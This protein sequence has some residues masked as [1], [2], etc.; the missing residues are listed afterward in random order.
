M[1]FFRA[2][3]IL[4]LSCSAANAGDYLFKVSENAEDVTVSGTIKA[5]EGIKDPLVEELLA[6][7]KELYAS[8]SGYDGIYF[9]A[10]G[11]A[12]YMGN[13]N[14]GTRD[15]GFPSPNQWYNNEDEYKRSFGHIVPSM[16]QQFN[17]NKKV[18]KRGD[19]GFGTTMAVGKKFWKGL[20]GEIELGYR[21]GGFDDVEI[22]ATKDMLKYETT[23]GRPVNWGEDD[24]GIDVVDGGYRTRSLLA[25]L[26]FDIPLTERF[27]PYV[28]AGVGLHWT[29]VNDGMSDTGGSG[30]AYQAM[31]GLNFKATDQ[32]ELFAGYRYFSADAVPM[33]DQLMIEVDTHN[34]EA[35]L[36]FYLDSPKKKVKDTKPPKPLDN[37]F[38][39]G[40]SGGLVQQQNMGN[41]LNEADYGSGIVVSN[42]EWK[43]GYGLEV[44]V[45]YRVCSWCRVEL[46][47]SYK[48]S[49]LASQSYAS[50]PWEDSELLTIE[51]GKNPDDV[52]NFAIFHALL[53]NFYADLNIANIKE[54]YGILPFLGVGLGGMYIDIQSPRHDEGGWNSFSMQKGSFAAQMS[55]GFGYSLTDQITV[56]TQYKYLTTLGN[57]ELF[58]EQNR[59]VLTDIEKSNKSY[60]VNNIGIHS[61]GLFARYNF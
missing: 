21:Q 31:A 52:S 40:I 47:Y 17:G 55:A 49:T 51:E 12:V 2:L 54:K 13:E 33:W 4:L 6:K 15:T 38:Y 36:R 30:L 39:V 22:L 1:I 26:I 14:I 37:P 5:G 41:F 28:G 10:S 57:D 29:T 45:G 32:L 43:A 53:I 27:S 60:R 61:Y 23:P 34:I 25:N 56:G 16:E 46:E 11:M 8:D 24:R 20:R 3:L 48:F 9:S 7:N 18:L 19:T 59:A 58:A 50:P 35:G 44:A 42:D